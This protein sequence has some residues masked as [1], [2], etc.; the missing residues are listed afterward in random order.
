MPTL[1]LPSEDHWTIQIK[2]S[3]GTAIGSI[4]LDDLETLHTEASHESR[5]TGEP[6]ITVLTEL[7]NDRLSTDKLTPNIVAVLV[8]YKHEQLQELKK[9]MGGSQK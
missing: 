3:D 4:S 2:G 1:Q 5:S 6:I 7:L 9:N 8:E